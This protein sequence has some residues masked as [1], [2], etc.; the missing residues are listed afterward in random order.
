VATTTVSY[1]EADHLNTP[2]LITNTAKQAVWSW[3]SNPFGSTLA[4]SNPSSLGVYTYNLR[5]PGQYFDSETGLHYNYHRDYRPDI[6]RYVQSDPIGLAGGINTFG[7]VEGD[8]ITK[9]D[10]L[11]LM[12]FS[13]FVKEKTGRAS[14]IECSNSSK[15]DY[16]RR[17]SYCTTFC[18]FE[19]NFPGRR[20]NFGPFRACIR[21]CMESAGF[22][23]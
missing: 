4:N 16:N 23:I 22:S 15:D 21:K 20:D 8:P 17:R 7:Y 14:S 5:F 11:G 1:I 6:G 2:R 18:Q 19:L 9:T 13:E 10:P 12:S 3:E